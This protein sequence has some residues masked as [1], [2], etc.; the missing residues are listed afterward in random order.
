MAAG[1]Y[2]Y[3]YCG[4]VIGFSAAAY[5]VHVL[6]VE[7]QVVF[8]GDGNAPAQLYTATYAQSKC[9]VTEFRAIYEVVVY[10]GRG[11][12]QGYAVAE[13]AGNERLVSIGSTLA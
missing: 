7:A 9:V 2:I 1:F 6:V 3:A 11:E 5:H 4:R 12:L 13:L 10:N 8:A